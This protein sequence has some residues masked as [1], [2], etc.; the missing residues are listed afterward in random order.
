M[1]IKLPPAIPDHRNTRLDELREALSKESDRGLIMV[2]ASFLNDAL[3]GLLHA[4]FCV[5]NRKP[6]SV[7]NALFN[8]FGPLSTFSAKINMAFA[9][10]LIEKWMYEDLEN[11]RKLRNE[12]AHGIRPLLF[13]SDEVR[14]LTEKL[15]GAD[16][17][18]TTMEKHKSELP[19]IRKK[20]ASKKRS[21]KNDKASME[22]LRTIMTVSY[23]GA[24]LQYRTEFL[25][26]PDAPMALKL[27]FLSEDR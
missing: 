16:H 14:K 23:I 21:T 17:F 20:K 19:K 10:D 24:V 9:I 13:D 11:L 26:F 2:S 25:E 18:V 12:F 6:K 1:N 4:K 15:A 8:S 27:N 5:I 7:L 22:R 3:E